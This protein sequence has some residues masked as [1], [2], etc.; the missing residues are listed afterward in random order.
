MRAAP[1]N[2]KTEQGANEN[3]RPTQ[4][5]NERDRQDRFVLQNQYR[6][7]NYQDQGP[8]DPRRYEQGNRPRNY[9]NDEI[10]DGEPGK[11]LAPEP[12]E[13]DST[14]ESGEIA[15]FNDI[16]DYDTEVSD[17]GDG[18]PPMT[19][20]SESVPPSSMARP[21][22]ARL[23]PATGLEPLVL[24][25]GLTTATTCFICQESFAS[26][27]ALRKHE[28]TRHANTR[29]EL[30][31]VNEIVESTAKP[32][33]IPGFAFRGYYYLRIPI[34]LEPYGQEHAV[35]LD[36]GATISLI[37]RAF[38]ETYLPLL[39]RHNLQ[40]RLDIQGLG[41]TQ[42]VEY[43]VLDFWIPSQK[44][45]NRVLAHARHELHV[46]TK[47][48]PKILLAMDVISSEGMKIDIPKKLVT[49]HACRKVKAPIMV[50]KRERVQLRTAVATPHEVDLEP[51]SV[52]PVPAETA[53][54]L[55]TDRDFEFTPESNIKPRHLF[56]YAYT[57]NASFEFVL[58][59]NQSDERVRL[60][61]GTRLGTVK[62]CE[63]VGCYQIDASE[64]GLAALPE[65]AS[66]RHMETTLTNG[67][68][69]YGTPGVRAQLTNVVMRFPS[70]W[71]DK[72]T[73][74]DVPEDEFMTIPLVEGW[75]NEPMSTKMYP[76]G[77]P[78]RKVVDEAFDKLHN[79]GKM[80]WGTKFTP[81]GFPVFVVWKY[82]M[83]N[84]Q[85]VRKGRA[86]I[87]I[88]NLNRKS[89]KDSYPLPLQSDI[90]SALL[91]C[92]YITTV[93]A[94]AF[95]YQWSVAE[96][97]RHKFTVNSHR[98]Q[99]FLKVAVMGYCN[100]V[101]YVQRRLDGILRECGSFAKA[102]IDD[103][104]IFSRTLT[105]HLHHLSVV[106]KILDQRRVSLSPLKSFIGFPSA[107]LLGQK[108]SGFGLSTHQEKVKAIV[109]LKFPETLKQLEAYIGLTGWQRS[110]IPYYSQ[111]IAPLEERK[112]SLLRDAPRK[113]NQRKRFSLK[114]TAFEPGRDC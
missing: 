17:L 3:G 40:A 23:V 52:T 45:G 42:S 108:V 26:R 110:H 57:L 59:R 31:I 100:S 11:E 106:F 92:A 47:L 2:A 88:R 30:P 62:E 43:V 39:Q 36:T 33:T 63:V 70:L 81:F 24:D 96:E 80:G 66:E 28:K 75:E 79:Q 68:T 101:Q 7:Q 72:G 46:V 82:S 18:C 61:K 54:S 9:H 5:R 55:P 95:F 12:V 48:K 97:D 67:I 109:G 21:T 29:P 60:P 13:S 34:R 90:I 22:R 56:P 102:Y 112:K 6:R 14:A 37:D 85:R 19:F 35:C 1:P 103:I 76:L 58:V 44:K 113:G 38:L 49:I 10:P 93:D 74:V 27:S 8:P 104:V 64:H 91:G 16:I 94:I 84:G 83:I 32:V 78:D 86:V 99:E 77:A 4:G 50:E 15:Q 107:T 105:D 41:A 51:N 25:K 73:T 111:I 89:P 98:G 53:R 87:D 20:F 69:V 71:E 114:T 65:R